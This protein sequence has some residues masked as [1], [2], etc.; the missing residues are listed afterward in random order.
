MSNLCVGPPMLLC[1]TLQPQNKHIL[2]ALDG[3]ECPVE[4][5][6]VKTNSGRRRRCRRHREEE[7]GEEEEDEGEEDEALGGGE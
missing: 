5:N 3:S 1:L 2:A 4:L 6:M 7:G